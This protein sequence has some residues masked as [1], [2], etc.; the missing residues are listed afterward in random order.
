MKSSSGLWKDV[1]RSIKSCSLVGSMKNG[2]EGPGTEAGSQVEAISTALR[3]KESGS[4][5]MY[6]QWNIAR[7]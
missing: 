7:P 4:Y 3:L 1:I 6:I 2:L 5:G